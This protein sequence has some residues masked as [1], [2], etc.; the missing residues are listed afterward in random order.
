M[1]SFSFLAIATSYIGFILGLTGFLADL[2]ASRGSTQD[3][4]HIADLAAS[5]G[6][7]QDPTHILT[8][9]PPHTRVHTP[10]TKPAVAVSNCSAAASA[11]N[12]A[13]ASA[14]NG[15]SGPAL[16]PPLPLPPP[17]WPA[18]PSLLPLLDVRAACYCGTVL[19]P[20]LIASINPG[21][22]LKVGA[23]LPA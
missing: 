2:A 16:L 18:P 9:A 14:A 11:A 21:A 6:S 19:P 12:G 4:T 10:P 5:R 1:Q 13:A 7:T 3:P 20:L 15:H 22:F 17:P 8:H 23:C